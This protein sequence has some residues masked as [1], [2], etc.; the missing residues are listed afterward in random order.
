[1]KLDREADG[2]KA[3]KR[4]RRAALAGASKI[5]VQVI[6][7]YDGIELVDPTTGDEVKFEQGSILRI[8]VLSLPK[9]K[10]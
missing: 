3:R 4:L 5:V 2:E 10:V 6:E 9:E 8:E 1:M 7:L